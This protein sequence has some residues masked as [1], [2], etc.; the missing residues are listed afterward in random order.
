MTVDIILSPFLL[1]TTAL[2]SFLLFTTAKPF[3]FACKM[4]GCQATYFCVSLVILVEADLTCSLPAVNL[5]KSL[6]SF[7]LRFLICLVHSHISLLLKYE[8]NKELRMFAVSLNFPL[9]VQCIICSANNNSRTSFFYEYLFPN[10][11][12]NG[13]HISCL[14]MC[15]FECLNV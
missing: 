9:N 10:V 8:N 2:P 11:T 14:L 7:H 5:K 1:F 4:F 3:S 15:C 6:F 12:Q 13:F